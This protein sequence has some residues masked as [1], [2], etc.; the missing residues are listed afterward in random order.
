MPH[1]VHKSTTCYLAISAAL[2][3]LSGHAL[4]KN[5]NTDKPA[6]LGEISVRTTDGISDDLLTAGLGKTGLAGPSPAIADPA[7]PTVAELRRLAI[8]NNYRALVDVNSSAAQR[9]RSQINCW[10][11]FR[12]SSLRHR[13]WNCF[14]LRWVSS[15][16][17]RTLHGLP[18]A[19]AT[20]SH[21]FQRRMSM[22]AGL[23]NWAT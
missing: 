22:L 4:A 12:P 11:G 19:A 7:N 13:R 1:F 23:A 18:S 2:L 5:E 9:M 8:Y 3:S 17:S 16:I 14:S 20:F 15:A 6:F 21:K 10:R